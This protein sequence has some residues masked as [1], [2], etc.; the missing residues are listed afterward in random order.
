MSRRRTLAL[1]TGLLAV[2]ALVLA[3]PAQAADYSYQVPSDASNHSFVSSN[4][5]SGD[6]DLGCHQTGFYSGQK[7]VFCVWMG[8]D[9]IINYNGNYTDV[10]EFALQWRCYNSSNSAVQCGNFQADLHL[11]YNDGSST[12]K[13]D[14][15]ASCDKNGGTFGSPYPNMCM[16]YSGSGTYTNNTGWFDADDQTHG[17]GTVDE[18]PYVHGYTLNESVNGTGVG[19]ADA[20]TWDVYD[21][22]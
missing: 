15:A 10:L 14:M 20:G 6:T 21:T 2:L 5:R 22:Y 18:W 3:G 19:S 16:G 11:T 17:R 8:V 13:L 4:E 12:V 7:A 1:L 9:N